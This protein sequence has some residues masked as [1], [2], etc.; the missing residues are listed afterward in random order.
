MKLDA[1]IDARLQVPA[2]MSVRSFMVY[3]TVSGIANFVWEIGQLPFYEIWT[4]GTRA[5]ISFAVLHCTVGDI[6]IAGFSLAVAFV[7]V[8]FL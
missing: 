3:L 6:L 8:R 1:E 4:E 2:Q 7:I 5:E